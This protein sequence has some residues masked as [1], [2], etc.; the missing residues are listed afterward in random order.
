MQSTDP[1]VS[2]LAAICHEPDDV[3]GPAGDRRQLDQLPILQRALGRAADD[4]ELELG[5]GARLAI[6]RVL[7]RALTEILTELAS[8]RARLR[9]EHATELASMRAEH[10]TELASLRTQHATELASLRAPN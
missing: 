8:L 1:C 9:N 10:A 6:Q 4:L 5:G 3:R 2:T 7:T